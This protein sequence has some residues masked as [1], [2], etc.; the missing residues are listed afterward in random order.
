MN[1]LLWH[2]RTPALGN[3]QRVGT[4]YNR[5]TQAVYCFLVGQSCCLWHYGCCSEWNS[6]LLQSHRHWLRIQAESFVA[7]W[8]CNCQY[9]CCLRIK[10]H[11]PFVVHAFSLAGVPSGQLPK[12]FFKL[13]VV[14]LAIPVPSRLILI[15]NETWNYMLTSPLLRLYVLTRKWRQ[16]HH[17]D[18]TEWLSCQNLVIILKFPTL[19]YSKM[20][21]QRFLE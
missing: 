6:G 3:W 18:N 17:S 8:I 11:N 15:G 5:Q 1:A 16:H 12:L 19:Y 13:H 2:L 9:F 7:T 4:G 14:C 21:T 20:K 10:N